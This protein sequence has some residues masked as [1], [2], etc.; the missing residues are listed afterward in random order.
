M[1]K[2][3]KGAVRAVMDMSVFVLLLLSGLLCS[4]SGLWREYHYINQSMSWSAAQSYCRVRFTDLATVDSMN[5]VNRT[6]NKVND[7]YSGSVWIGLNRGTQS[8]WGWSTGDDTLA[9]YSPWY[10]GDPN[11]DGECVL[12]KDNGWCDCSFTYK[13]YFVCYDE[14]TGNIIKTILKNWTD[15]QSYCRKYDTDLATIHNP[16]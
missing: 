10:P 12:F 5:D 8:R 1:L 7:G 14:T 6:M 13:L 9:Q 15:A 4:A 16:V 3:Q 11:G 2:H